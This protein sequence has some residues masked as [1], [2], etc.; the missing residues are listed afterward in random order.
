M[1]LDWENVVEDWDGENYWRNQ[2]WEDCS[3]PKRNLGDSSNRDCMFASKDY[4]AAVSKPRSDVPVAQHVYS[5]FLIFTV[6]ILFM[7]THDTVG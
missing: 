1:R 7:L 6:D 2:A 5:V 4:A 3:G